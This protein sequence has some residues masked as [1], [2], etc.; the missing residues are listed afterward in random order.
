MRNMHLLLLLLIIVMAVEVASIQVNSVSFAIPIRFRTLQ[1]RGG[2][3]KAVPQHAQLSSYVAN[4]DV[5]PVKG[6]E[7]NFDGAIDARF[8]AI[9]KKLPKDLHPIMV[10]WFTVL[11]LKVMILMSMP[12]SFISRLVNLPTVQAFVLLSTP[13]VESLICGLLLVLLRSFNAGFQYFKK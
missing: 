1:S 2:A 9:E 7:R 13:I 8:A 3:T 4:A 10:W 5:E 11:L 12:L 6:V